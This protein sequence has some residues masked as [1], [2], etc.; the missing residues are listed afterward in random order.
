MKLFVAAIC[1]IAVLTGQVAAPPT[2]PAADIQSI[3]F[4][5]AV[6]MGQA[7][8]EVLSS[9][10]AVRS[11]W[12]V[13]VVNATSGEVLYSRNESLPFTPA[14]NTKLFSSALALLRLGPDHRLMTRVLADGVVDGNGVLYGDLVLVGGGDPTLS[15]RLYPY[16]RTGPETDPLLGIRELAEQVAE[17]GIRTIAGNI[18]GDDTLFPWEPIPQ[19]WTVDDTVWSYG[20]PISA[21]SFADNSVQLTLVPGAFAGDTPEL[22]VHPRV[23]LLTFLNRTRTTS[24]RGNSI[25]YRRPPGSYVVDITGTIQAGSRNDREQLAVP[26]PALFAAHAFAQE[27]A[28]LGI[29]RRGA[30][31]SRHRDVG[32]PYQEPAGGVVAFRISPPL[33]EMLQIVNK[34]SQNLHAELLLR[35]AARATRGD[36]SVDNGVAEMKALMSELGLDKGETEFEDGSGLSRKTLV[37]PRAVTALLVRMNQSLYS[38]HWVDLMPIG[39]VDGSLTNRFSGIREASTIRAKTGSLSHVSALSGY[40]LR[41]DGGRLAFSI[42]VNHYTSPWSEIRT[43]IDKIGAIIS[44]SG[45]T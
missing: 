11:L 41:R 21:L 37:T 25:T 3:P 31:Q 33:S 36:G 10:A 14:S 43:L 32:Q 12:G 18:V 34:V 23:E 6:S 19:G 38:E 16:Q 5:P 44:T 8:D 17:A 24:G 26:D 9:P 45:T 29:A 7:I 40:A 13:R 42:I 15:G 20:A 22:L 35:E 2:P 28:G 1:G 39:G 4:T 27:L 30:V